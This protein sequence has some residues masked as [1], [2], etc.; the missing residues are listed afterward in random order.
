MCRARRWLGAHVLRPL[1]WVLAVVGLFP[2]WATMLLVMM[3]PPSSLRN[4]DGW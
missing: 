3:L 2:V 4:Y 1:G